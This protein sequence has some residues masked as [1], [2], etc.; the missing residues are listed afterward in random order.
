MRARERR[1][2]VDVVRLEPPPRGG[3]V[4]QYREPAPVIRARPSQ[5]ERCPAP[6]IVVLRGRRLCRCCVMAVT[7]G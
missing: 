4:R 7:S 3:T 1:R 2:G 5:C 6:G